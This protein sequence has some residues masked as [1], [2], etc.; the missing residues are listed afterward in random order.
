MVTGEH[1]P[2]DEEANWPSDDEKEEEG[3]CSEAK[4]KMKI[5]EV[6]E[7]KTAAED[8]WVINNCEI[9]MQLA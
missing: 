4:S 6:A 3:L 8:K 5:E 7:N 1:E 2:T 9:D